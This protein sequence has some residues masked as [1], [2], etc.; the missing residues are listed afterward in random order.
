MYSH[1]IWDFNGTILDDV[2]VGIRSINTLLSRRGLRLIPNRA[3]YQAVFGFP[4]MEY[5][6]RIGLDVDGEG[7]DALAAEWVAEYEKNRPNATVYDGVRE[8]L[9]LFASRCCAQLILSA[10]EQNLLRQEL[11]DLNLYAYFSE[12]IGSD[13]YY[14][15]GK[16]EAARRWR[17]VHPDASVLLIGDTVHDYEVSRILN[18]DCVLTAAGHQNAE[19]LRNCGV[20]VMKDMHEICEYFLNYHKN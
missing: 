3:A 16:T 10:C 7:F 15:D 4:V 20:P 13:N 1:I 14:G 2:E 12:L 6:R 18:A 11:H 19:Q 8:L 9:D 5:Y 17:N